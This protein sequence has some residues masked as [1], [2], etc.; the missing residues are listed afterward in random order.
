[1]SDG[2]VTLPTHSDIGPVVALVAA[3]GSSK[4]I[5]RKN[6]QDLCGKPL[7]VR[8]LEAAMAAKTVDLVM[9]ST[10]ND[11]IACVCEAAGVPVPYRRPAALATDQASMLDVVLDALD[12]LEISLRACGLLVLLQPTSPLRTG[13]HIDEAVDLFRRT[14]AELLTSVH[15]VRE[16]PFDC[17]A[18]TGRGAIDGR[19]DWSFM[20]RP[21]AA[22]IRRQDYERGFHYVNGALYLATPEALRRHRAFLVEGKTVLYEM[23]MLD[24]LDIDEVHDL[25]LARALVEYRMRQRASSR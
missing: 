19:S 20:M 16:H 25:E 22:R 17:V 3:R 1:M 5:P 8:S 11:D 7:I 10:E 4:G 24:G 21:D 13:R 18:L 15:S 2:R 12:Y 23:D 14:E 6:L 9:V